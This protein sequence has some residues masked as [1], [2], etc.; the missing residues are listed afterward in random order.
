M[1]LPR[2]PAAVCF[3]MDGLLF[4][5]ETLYAEAI[6]LAAGEFGREMPEALFRRLIGEP[7]TSNRVLLIA[8]WGSPEE[9]ERL[10]GAWMRHFD[11]LAAR[12]LQLK[13]GA[14]ELVTAVEVLGL[15][16]AIVTSSKHEEVAR[17]LRLHGLE[18]R[19]QAVIAREDYAR[20]KPAPEPYQLAARR[21]DVEPAD[22]LALEDSH[23]GVRSAAGAG[24]TVVMVPDLLPPTAAIRRLCVGVAKDL[25]AVRRALATAG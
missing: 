10:H 7:W 15:P 17:N 25:H 20:G 19:F 4:D 9:V 1:R 11:A 8:E 5:T 22:C 13:P 18:G 14:R 21:L 3:D 24:M 12:R 2:T 16:K 6:Q 23:A